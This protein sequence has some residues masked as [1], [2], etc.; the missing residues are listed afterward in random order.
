MFSGKEKGGKGRKRIEKL[1]GRYGN[2]ERRRTKQ[3]R[4]KEI[5]QDR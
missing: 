4:I 2:K 5:R 3:M 1:S